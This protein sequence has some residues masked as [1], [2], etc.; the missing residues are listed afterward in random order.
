MRLSKINND[1]LSIILY[2]L[3]LISYILLNIVFNAY[4]KY[5]F[6]CITFIK[7]NYKK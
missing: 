6:T 2:K 5:K 4:L 1:M 3:L 7:F